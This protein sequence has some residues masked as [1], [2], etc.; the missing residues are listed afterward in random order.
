MFFQHSGV[1]KFNKNF[2]EEVVKVKVILRPTVSRPV[3]PSVRQPSEIRDQF[4]KFFFTADGL[5]MWG[6]LSDERT[7]LWYIFLYT[8]RTA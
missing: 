5:L 1:S 6:A 7:D 8:I 4:V 2:W 3:R